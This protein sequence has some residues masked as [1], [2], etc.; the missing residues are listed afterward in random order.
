VVG[1]MKEAYAVSRATKCKRFLVSVSLNLS[2][3][4]MVG[5]ILA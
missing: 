4:P 5:Q 3:S 1:A 2:Y